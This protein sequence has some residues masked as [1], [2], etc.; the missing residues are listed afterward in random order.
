MYVAF[1]PGVLPQAKLSHAVGV[2]SPGQ[3]FDSANLMLR[4]DN[5]SPHQ[6]QSGDESPHSK[7]VA[8]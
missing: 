2:N 7:S 6:I 1:F 4:S 8:R 5:G 3:A